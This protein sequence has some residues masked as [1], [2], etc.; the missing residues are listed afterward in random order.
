MRRPRAFQ[1]NQARR[2]GCKNPAPKLHRVS[3]PD[4]KAHAS[5]RLHPPQI[6]QNETTDEHRCTQ[7]TPTATKN[8]LAET[9][10]HKEKLA[11]NF[12]KQAGGQSFCITLT[13]HR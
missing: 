2:R 3:P 8:L 10:R 12:T 11:T 4:P 1:A 13:T 6:A 9:Q 5:S 7:C